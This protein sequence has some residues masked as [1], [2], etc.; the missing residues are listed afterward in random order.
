MLIRL[1]SKGFFSKFFGAS[2]FEAASS[3][4]ARMGA[5]RRT[6][7]PAREIRAD[8]RA[9]GRA[10]PDGATF[11]GAR[12]RWLQSAAALAVSAAPADIAWRS[13]HA[14]SRSQRFT[15]QAAPT[16]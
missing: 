4:I 2:S 9:R 8:G 1:N 11:K 12:L 10:T 3:T 5:N 14:S 13:F 6:D 7:L 15:L 16:K